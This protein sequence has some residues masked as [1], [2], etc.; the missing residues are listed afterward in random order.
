MVHFVNKKGHNEYIEMQKNLIK[1]LE[2]QLNSDSEE[3]I[4]SLK[5]E[6]GIL[7]AQIN[8]YERETLKLN[9]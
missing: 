1:L 3:E 4:E 8:N 5:K 2:R 6:T 9:I 7:K